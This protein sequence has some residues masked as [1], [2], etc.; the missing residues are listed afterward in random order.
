MDGGTGFYRGGRKERGGGKAEAR[1]D[2]KKEKRKEVLDKMNRIYR[3]G[4]REQVAG[5]EN[6]TAR[7]GEARG[8]F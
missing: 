8:R 7:G 2:T 6:K 5:G 1:I 4:R 3:M